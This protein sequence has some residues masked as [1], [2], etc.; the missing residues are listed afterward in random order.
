[1]LVI[2]GM[3]FVSL[4]SE[5]C[6]LPKNCRSQPPSRRTTSYS[7]KYSVKKNIQVAFWCGFFFWLEI[8][9]FLEMKRSVKANFLLGGDWWYE[10]TDV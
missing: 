1:M 7:T 6:Q 4:C 9:L 10:N 5:H 8:Y 3:G 2:K